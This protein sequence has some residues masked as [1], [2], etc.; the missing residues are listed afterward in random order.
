MKKRGIV[1]LSVIAG[2]IITVFAGFK[3]YDSYISSFTP[4]KWETH[5]WE[6]IK[7]IDSLTEQYDL[8]KMNRGEVLDLLGTTGLAESHV[9][10]TRLCYYAGKGI[11]DPLLFFVNF[12]EGGTAYDYGII[13]G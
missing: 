4:Q 2:I 7:M 10:D 12:N 8:H 6:R 1:I 11:I 9:S 5:R 13:E 3:C